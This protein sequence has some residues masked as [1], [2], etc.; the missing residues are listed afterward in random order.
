MSKA[1]WKTDNQKQIYTRGQ[2][3][4]FHPKDTLTL[5]LYIHILFVAIKRAKE[6]VPDNAEQKIKKIL[7]YIY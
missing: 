1:Q 5:G 4:G 3:F 6:A 7:S 2:K